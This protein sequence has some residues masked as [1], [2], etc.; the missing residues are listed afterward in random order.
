MTLATMLRNYRKKSG[1]SQID[2]SKILG[3]STSQFIS[4]WER[5]VA[6]VPPKIGRKVAKVLNIPVDQ[7]KE[8]LREEYLADFERRFK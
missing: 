5:G 6:S 4:N 7:M 2:V 1:L 8:K 3:Y